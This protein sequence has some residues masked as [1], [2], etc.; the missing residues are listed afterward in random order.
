MTLAGARDII[1]YIN[2][3]GGVRYENDRHKRN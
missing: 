1:K 2:V 3:R